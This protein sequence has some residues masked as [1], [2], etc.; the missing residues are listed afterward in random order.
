MLKV[1]KPYYSF[2]RVAMLIIDQF[3]TYEFFNIQFFICFLL[4]VSI[5][6]GTIQN[7]KKYCV[8][9]NIA[10]LNTLEMCDSSFPAFYLFN[11]TEPQKPVVK[12][13]QRA[14]THTHPHPHIY[15]YFR[16]QNH[17]RLKHWIDRSADTLEGINK[18]C[19]K[20]QQEIGSLLEIARAKELEWNSIMRLL[21]LKE[22][23]LERVL[24]KKRQ[25]EFNGGKPVDLET[26]IHKMHKNNYIVT[27]EQNNKVTFT[28]QFR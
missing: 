16:F 12:Y 24:F 17:N 19:E 5:S 2:H 8:T 27:A 21:K 28:F 9:I 4:A 10:K 23:M 15:I 3:G 6:A 20:L 11:H 7:S 22:E 26:N 13:D 18:N 14:R 1:K 25:A